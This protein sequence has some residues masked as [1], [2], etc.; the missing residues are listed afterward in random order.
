MRLS[1]P[2]R[3]LVAGLSSSGGF[4]GVFFGLDLAWWFS[5][6]AGLGIYVGAIL[7][8]ERRGPENGG[9]RAPHL[10]VRDQ[11]QSAEILRSSAERLRTLSVQSE[12]EDQGL[13][14]EMSDRLES[15]RSH[16]LADPRD[17]KHTRNFV[18][19]SL[20]R[21][22]EAA[23]KYVEVKSRA[24]PSQEARLAEVGRSIRGYLPILERIDA[25]CLENDFVG[26]ELHVEALNDQFRRRP[27][28]E[29]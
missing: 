7:L 29:V 4:L 20:P 2:M 1:E 13:F 10:E 25:A 17:H 5:L 27:P 9:A 15:I 16:Q 26:L 14:R 19:S 11:A 12:G 3:Q 8:I 18:R 6:L 22:I 24:Q 28:G 21:M 23:E